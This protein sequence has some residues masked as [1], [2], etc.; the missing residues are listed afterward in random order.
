MNSKAGNFKAAMFD[1]DGTL[2]EKGFNY[3]SQDVV[4]ALVALSQK[5]PIGFCT[6]R[7]LESFERRGLSKIL[8]CVNDEER[9]R[10]LENLY[11]F[12]ENGAIGYDYNPA[13]KNFE[14]IYEAEWPNEFIEREK[15]RT[16][17]NEAVKE[18]GGI[19]YDAHEIVVVMGTKF[20]HEDMPA[21]DKVYEFAG[22][23]YD[24]TLKVLEGINPDYAKY[25]H[26]GNSGIGVIVGPAN[27]DKDEAIERF[28]QFLSKTRGLEFGEGY[29]EI[30]TVGD[31]AQAGGNDYYFLSGR[32]GTPY[33]V[34]D[35]LPDNPLLQT[36]RDDKGR[37]V[38][39]AKGTL[40]L[41]RELL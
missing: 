27:S 26:V 38:L 5:I 24:I 13:I 23:I 18:Y 39:N 30:L 28:G 31:S 9:P 10:F 16:I 8:E 32:F 7:Q 33:S 41:I 37:R 11:L 36:V 15:L 12:S 40:E 20:Y 4:D 19:L 17:L 1:F 34:G 25:V 6:G 29:R 21:I 14:K 35:V 2:T 3:P 22:K